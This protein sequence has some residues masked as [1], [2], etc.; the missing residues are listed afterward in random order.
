MRKLLFVII[1][2]MLG[3]KEAKKEVSIDIPTQ[4]FTTPLGKEFII[5]KSSERMLEL[6]EKG[7]RNFLFFVN[8]TNII[9]KT[10][11]NFLNSSSSKYLFADKIEF[12]G[13]SVEIKEVDNFATTDK[14]AININF[15]TIQKL[16][17]DL[18]GIKENGLS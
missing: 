4:K 12:N 5:P 1:L 13:R 9:E 8:S 2:F 15:T 3:C 17:T 10:R 18:N 6:Y 14:D 7:Y 11:D 16:H